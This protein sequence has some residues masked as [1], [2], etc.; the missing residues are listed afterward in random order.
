MKHK[1]FALLFAVLFATL[2]PMIAFAQAD[3]L[4][5]DIYLTGTL[6]SIGEGFI[7][8]S[9]Q[10]IDITQVEIDE[11]LVIGATVEMEFAQLADGSLVAI[12]VD[13]PDDAES[14]FYGVIESIEAE[15][16]VVSGFSFNTAYLTVSFAVGDPVEVEFIVVNEI[17]YALSIE[18][19]DADDDQNDDDD[20]D[21]DDDEAVQ[22]LGIVESLADGMIVISGLTIDTSNATVA[23]NVFVGAL[24]VVTFTNM[25]DDDN[26]VW[27]A[28]SV[29]LYSDDDLTFSGFID[30]ITDTTVTVSSLTF[31]ITTSEI[32]SEDGLAVGDYVDVDFMLDENGV[33]IATSVRE[34]SSNDD[35]D[36]SDV[37]TLELY[38]TIE[39][40]DATSLTVSGTTFDISIAEI[41]TPNELAVGDMVEVEYLELDGVWVALEVHEE[42]ARTDDD[43]EDESDDDDFGGN[44][45]DIVQTEPCTQPVGW[46]TYTVVEGD[47]LSL[48]AVATDTDLDDLIEVNCLE[49]SA[50]IIVGQVLFVENEFAFFNDDDDD[51]MN[52]DDDGSNDDN[53]DHDGNDD[54]DDNDDSGSDDDGNDDQDDDNDDDDNDGDN[55][56]DDNDDDNDDDDNQP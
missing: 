8:V 42:D 10:Q 17:A 55:D 1:L 22:L 36:D 2:S 26:P 11:V 46:T 30:E 43:D 48:I 39:A 51:D 23:E 28:V 25:G 19:E 50:V 53:D 6:E 12:E 49:D 18:A 54:Q 41:H 21:Q 45:D 47:T 56:D 3:D 40:I 33:Y 24:V 4:S 7:V 27:S 13:Y 38:G 37:E 20:S 31:D 15:S 16:I 34:A 32:E 35:D 14:Y 52:D 44:D 5:D 29:E 9:G